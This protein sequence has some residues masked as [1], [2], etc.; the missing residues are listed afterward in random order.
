MYAAP[1]LPVAS[2]R[3]FSAIVHPALSLPVDRGMTGLTPPQPF[4]RAHPLKTVAVVA[5]QGRE[6]M[7]DAV[8]EAGDY[9]VVVIESIDHAY[10]HLKLAAPHIVI[11]FVDVDDPIGLQVLSMLKLDRDTSNIPV[12]THFSHRDIGSI[13]A[14]EMPAYAPTRRSTASMN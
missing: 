14:L 2:S 6:D 10:S 11:L 4:Q 1:E 3:Q 5:Q 7:L 12:I 8:L 9:D 13:D